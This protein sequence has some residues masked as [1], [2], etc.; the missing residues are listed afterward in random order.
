MRCL[1]EQVEGKRGMAFDSHKKSDAW[2]FAVDLVKKKEY[3][4]LIAVFPRVHF[5]FDSKETENGLKVKGA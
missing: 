3:I 2:R 5:W 4:R 1:R